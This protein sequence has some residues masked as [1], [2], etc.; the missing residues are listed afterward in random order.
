MIQEW[1]CISIPNRKS[2]WVDVTSFQIH[3]AAPCLARVTPFMHSTLDLVHSP[4]FDLRFPCCTQHNHLPSWVT[5]NKMVLLRAT[6]P[7]SVRRGENLCKLPTS[8]FPSY[9][10]V[11]VVNWSQQCRISAV[12]R[13]QPWRVI[14][15]V[16]TRVLR[17]KKDLLRGFCY[18]A[19]ASPAEWISACDFLSNAISSYFTACCFSDALHSH[20]SRI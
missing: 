1:R 16:F 6:S 3:V 9:H 18:T 15:G 5:L 13:Q 4:D 17:T 20:L 2:N 11:E 8:F 12:A 10:S 19:L 14:G 7:A